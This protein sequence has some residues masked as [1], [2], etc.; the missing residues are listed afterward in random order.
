M[1][2]TDPHHDD[3]PHEHPDQCVACLG[4]CLQL[5]FQVARVKVCNACT[6]RKTDKVLYSGPHVHTDSRAKRPNAYS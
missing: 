5:A 6:I 4:A 2:R 1:M 3:D